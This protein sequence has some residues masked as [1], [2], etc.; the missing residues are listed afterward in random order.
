MATVADAGLPEPPPMALHPAALAAVDTPP[1]TPTVLAVVPSTDAAD[2]A[3]PPPT[4]TPPPVTSANVHVTFDY[5][6]PPPAEG[7]ITDGVFL[8]PDAET[9]ATSTSTGDILLYDVATGDVTGAFAPFPDAPGA[10][11]SSLSVLPARHGAPPQ[12]LVVG[13]RGAGGGGRRLLRVWT[14]EAGRAVCMGSVGLP[15]NERDVLMALPVA[16]VRGDEAGEAGEAGGAAGVAAADGTLPPVA[17]AL[18]GGPRG[19]AADGGDDPADAAAS[20]IA[21]AG[22]TSARHSLGTNGDGAG[23]DAAAAP[24]DGDATALRY[25][26]GASGGLDAAGSGG[27]AGGGGR[28]EEAVEEEEE[29]VVVDDSDADEAGDDADGGAIARADDSGSDYGVGDMDGPVVPAVGATAGRG[30][31]RRVASGGASGVGS[32]GVTGATGDSDS[33]EAGELTTFVTAKDKW[34]ALEEATKE[35]TSAPLPGAQG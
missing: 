21:A 9:V 34:G 5:A 14:V 18:P 15:Q 7:I 26:E 24:G 13:G 8:S 35:R 10:P 22:R 3:P 4:L 30:S 11:V 29:E 16:V 20:W 12:L 28:A 23:G 6:L 2:A 1:A 17:L 33:D 25:R 31:G 32:G 19:A 27:G